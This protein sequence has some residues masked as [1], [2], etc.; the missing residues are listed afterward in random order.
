MYISESIKAA[1]QHN[2][3]KNYNMLDYHLDLSKR[4]YNLK[5]VCEKKLLKPLQNQISNRF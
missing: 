1:N 5:L 3:L 2:L 4:S